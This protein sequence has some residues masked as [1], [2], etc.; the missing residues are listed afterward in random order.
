MQR[1]LIKVSDLFVLIDPPLH[2][3]VRLWNHFLDL[4][5]TRGALSG[6]HPGGLLVG[7]FKSCWHTFWSNRSSLVQGIMGYR[8]IKLYFLLAF[9]VACGGNFTLIIKHHHRLWRSA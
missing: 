9:L 1:Y 7:L 8:P 3:L 2:D 4:Q 5:Y 6:W